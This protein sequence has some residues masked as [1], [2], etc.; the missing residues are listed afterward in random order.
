MG[1]VRLTYGDLVDEYIRLN[2]TTE[3][4]A[5]VPVGRYINFMGDFLAA[6]KG[7]TGERARSA[8]K[9]LQ[10]LDV[11]KNYRSWVQVRSSKS[12]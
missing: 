3:P 1:G 2:Q 5:R 10:F 7:A 11:P 12:R 8:W 4:F 6:E 9:K